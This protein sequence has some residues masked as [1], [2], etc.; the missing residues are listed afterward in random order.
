MFYA[1]EYAYGAHVINNGNR[2]DRPYQFTR[3]ELRDA[4]VQDGPPDTHASG[5]REALSSRNPAIRKAHFVD[6]GDALGWRVLGERR[7]ANS[8]ALSKHRAIISEDWSE[9]DHW[10][11]VAT[12]QEAA[13]VSWAAATEAAAYPAEN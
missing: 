4:W 7:I 10:R 11:W 5:Y 8:E 1:I 6:D 3:R 12:A 2:A 9:R 13:I